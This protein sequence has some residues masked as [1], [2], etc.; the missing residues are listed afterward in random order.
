MTHVSTLRC[1]I[2]GTGTLPMQCAERLITQGHLLVG[3]VS[4]D[5]DIQHW[6][7]RRRIPYAAPGPAAE[8]LLRRTPFDYLFSI[9][10]LTVLPTEWLHLA[11]LGAINYHDGPLPRYAGSYV[12]S[13]ALLNGEQ[14]HGISWHLMNEKMDAGDV[15]VQVPVS[16]DPDETALS[17]N[18]KCYDAALR[19]FGTLL[20]GLARHTIRAHAQNLARRTFISRHRRPPAAATLRWDQPAASLDRLVRALT[21]G[22]Y[23]NPLALPRL[24]LPTPGMLHE[25]VAVHALQ[26]QAQATAAQPGSVLA[27]SDTALLVATADHPVAL[28]GFSSPDGQPLT[29]AELVA[30]AGLGVG[31]QLP[32]LPDSLAQ[33][34]TT[35]HEAINRFEPFWQT[36][37]EEATAPDLP[38]LRPAQPAIAPRYQ[39]AAL[40][41]P[42]VFLSLAHAP[43]RG[44][45]AR[46]VLLTALCVYLA[47]LCGSTRFDLALASS[48]LLQ[49][50]ELVPWFA[51]FVPLALDLA[52]TQSFDAVLEDVHQQLTY[53]IRRRTFLRDL[54]A[55]LPNL[56]TP[57]EL[58]IAITLLDRPETIAPTGAL[59]IALDPTARRCRWL[60][61]PQRI[62]PTELDL[63]QTQFGHFLHALA[64]APHTPLNRIPLLSPAER[65]RIL[66]EWNATQRPL[67]PDPV[68]RLVAAQAARTPERIAVETGTQQLSYAELD[69]QAHA[70]AG[71]LAELGVGPERLVG[72]CV[73]RSTAMLVAM[74]AILKAGAAYLP[75]DPEYPADRVRAMASD[76]GI[77]HL[78]TDEPQAWSA[79]GLTLITPDETGSTPL[80][81]EV[82]TLPEQLAY[83]IYTSGS[84]GRPKGVQIPHRALTN[85]LLSMLEQPGLR[86]DDTLLAVTTLSFDI[87]GLELWLPLLA[88]ARVIIADRMTA[89]DGQRLL[90]LLNQSGTTVMQATPATWRMLIAAGWNDSPGLTALCGG[91]ALP[92]DL[93]DALRPRVAKLWNMYGPTETTI[94]STLAD[95]TDPNEPITIGRPIA[96][97]RCYILDAAGEPLP[98][99]VIGELCI[100]GAGVAR[101]YLGRPELTAER[102]VPDPFDPH[103]ARIYRT[104]DLARY[105]PDGRIECLGRSDQQVK[106]RGFRIEPGEIETRL[107]E[108]PAVRQAAVVARP[109]SS[110]EARLIAYIVTRTATLPVADIRAFLA[111]ALPEYMVPGLFVNLEALPLTP[112][113]KINRQALPEP[114][115]AIRSTPYAEPRTPIE[116]ELTDLWAELLQLP[117]IG[118]DDHFFELGGHS[119]L[120]TRLVSRIREIFGVDLALR[121]VFEASTPGTL[122][123]HLE[124][125]RWANTGSAPRP[126]STEQREEGDL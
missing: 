95:Q 62:T 86:P 63:L 122:A 5:A 120:A 14:Q 54:P 33:R 123:V 118:R 10:N 52:L 77:T 93:A 104:G 55:R 125:L 76:S 57:P 71:R 79:L 44:A 56:P 111:A 42:P 110:G 30:R 64:A 92:P 32:V 83:T 119:L 47:R 82:D 75:I 40:H 19:S 53:T 66:V 109:D 69:Q 90:A 59:T 112:N 45:A 26:V 31:A 9:V 46:T 107:H 39:E 11:R 3:V 18:L 74:L 121:T 61:D 81:A 106:V 70:L 108:H 89:A 97:T 101:G 72:L 68:H 29:V 13:W 100:G 8:V 36:R 16:I 4:E 6:A 60:F 49:Q 23:P 43:E 85:F 103:G 73:Q 24:L 35:L 28:Q 124:A 51:P 7:S 99:G 21:F 22:R 65:Q 50:P 113:G 38:F 84:T 2:I 105:L 80:P 20:D 17:L 25:T 41:V 115:G 94:W 27:I 114:T 37:L 88:G 48:D 98:A 96:N 87:A 1:I 34:I 12:T 78:I 15:L 116:R 126:P 117:G 67:L 102:F 58:P 91:E